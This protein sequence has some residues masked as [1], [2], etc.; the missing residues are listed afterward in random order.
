MTRFGLT[1]VRVR[2]FRTL[3]DVSF[4]P[5]RLSAFVG[6][7]HAGKSN[8]LAAIRLLLD[9]TAPPPLASDLAGT[10][11]GR[12]RIDG[13]MADG[14]ALSVEWEPDGPAH[15]TGSAPVLFVP[16]GQRSVSVIEP[17]EE[18]P[19]LGVDGADVL[20]EAIGDLAA[21][22]DEEGS[23]AAPAN[24]LVEF[25]EAHGA[26]GL[27]GV[28]IL[29]EEPELF[30]RPQAQRYLYRLLRKAAS[31][32]NQV[33]YSTHSPAFLNVARIEDLV[34]VERRPGR[35]TRVIQPQPLPPDE[36]FRA[37]SEFDA[38]RAELFLARA[39]VL[40]EGLTEKLA[41]PFAF[42]ALGHDPDREAISIVECGG[43]SNIPL[44][45]GVC[46]A[47]GIPY[48]AVHDRDAPVGVRPSEEEQALND[49]IT[50]MAKPA[51]TVVLAPDFEGVA[52]LA[53]RKHKPTRAWERFRSLTPEEVP[54]PLA[55]AVELAVGLA[56][57]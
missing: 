3:E 13:R 12:I 9:Q 11:G 39:A 49:L 42:R 44:F 16:A 50:A 5:S 6:E 27:N 14:P 48:I 54:A 4:H 36:E 18:L 24:A 53:G 19:G 33:L 45:A 47:V 31:S 43:K 8:L 51:N 25:F 37:K 46:A 57:S 56:R 21:S 38:E 34:L 40:V 22:A 41:L 23:D 1:E 55:R 26:G 29:I 35:E 10:A 17:T 30:L 20:D 15:R 32:G 2:G 28:V 7:A 52:D